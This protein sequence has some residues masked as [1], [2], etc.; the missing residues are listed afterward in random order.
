[1]LFDEIPRDELGRVEYRRDQAIQCGPRPTFA[2]QD[3]PV[4][5]LR[6]RD[7]HLRVPSDRRRDAAVEIAPRLDESSLADFDVRESSPRS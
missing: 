1:L 7:K 6:R 5:K 2:E 3:R 4:G